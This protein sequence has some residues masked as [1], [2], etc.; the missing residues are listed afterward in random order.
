MQEPTPTPLHQIDMFA[1]SEP[2]MSA[3]DAMDRTLDRVERS[4]TEFRERWGVRDDVDARSKALEA[5][6]ASIVGADMSLRPK[7]WARDPRL[8]GGRIA[9]SRAD[10]FESVLLAGTVTVPKTAKVEIAEQRATGYADTLLPSRVIRA[11]LPQPGKTV[12][13]GPVPG[14]RWY[15]RFA[16]RAA[17]AAGAAALLV[18]AASAESRSSEMPPRT[19]T[20]V[21]VQTNAR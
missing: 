13:S 8:D 4:L 14:E 5:I 10:I 21:V 17:V 11:V 12:T 2:G 19:D 15:N 6:G 7:V 3:F 1:H 20:S 18:G 16:T 9:T